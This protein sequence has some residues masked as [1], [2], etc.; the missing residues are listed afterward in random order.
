MSGDVR[1]PVPDQEVPIRAKAL[2]IVVAAVLALVGAP[3]GGSPNTHPASCDGKPV[4]FHIHRAHVRVKVAYALER[5][6]HGPTRSAIAD[7]QR[8]KRCVEI[9]KVRSELHE[10]RVKLA[11]RLEA[12]ANEQRQ[13]A[14]ITPPGSEYLAGLRA[15]ESG[16]DYSTNTGN[17]FYGAYQF[18]LQT[19]GS[20]GGSGLPSAA[21]PAEQDYRAALLWRQRG[22]APWPVC[23]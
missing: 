13:V 11:A 14:D 12:Y 23:G 16:G 9:A 8:H 2:P 20:V 21:A 1:L 5:W 6:Q 22:S 10:L 18:D 7:Y 15:C 4:T 17:G 3:A 19:W